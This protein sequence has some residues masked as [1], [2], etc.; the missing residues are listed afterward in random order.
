MV[1]RIANALAT[2]GATGFIV[3]LCVTFA[4]SLASSLPVETMMLSIFIA[5]L[6]G[7]P[8]C[9]AVGRGIRYFVAMGVGLA[10]LA[11]RLGKRGA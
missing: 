8:A 7:P 4:N 3:L 1:E 11:F 5:A 10:L 9:E 2:A 6:V